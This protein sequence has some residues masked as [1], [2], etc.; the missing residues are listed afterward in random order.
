M[1]TGFYS[2]GTE[3]IVFPRFSLIVASKKIN[4]EARMCVINILVSKKHLKIVE[5]RSTVTSRSRNQPRRVNESH[6]C[7]RLPLYDVAL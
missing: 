2:R 1:L 7:L 6:I 5:I 3:I 4:Y